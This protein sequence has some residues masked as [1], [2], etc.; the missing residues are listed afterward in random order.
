MGFAISWYDDYNHDKYEGEV[1]DTKGLIGNLATRST[2]RGSK[3]IHTLMDDMLEVIKNSNKAGD[4]FVK[5]ECEWNKRIELKS[6][7]E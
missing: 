7:S 1:G 6:E 5:R 4:L 3:R 2:I